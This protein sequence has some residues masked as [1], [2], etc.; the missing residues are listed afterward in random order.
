MKPELVLP[1][2][3]PGEERSPHG[4]IENMVLRRMKGGDP[5]KNEAKMLGELE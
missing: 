5:A 4:A 2:R 3:P 1:C